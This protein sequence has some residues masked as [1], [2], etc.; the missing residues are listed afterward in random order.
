MSARS[1]KLLPEGRYLVT[2]SDGHGARVFRV[3]H[4]GLRGPR[5]LWQWGTPTRECLAGEW[6]PGQAAARVRVGGSVAADLRQL[7]ADPERAW[8]A[9]L[10]E[11]QRLCP[12]VVLCARC[13]RPLHDPASVQ[14]GEGPDCARHPVGVA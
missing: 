10:T 3:T 9:W 2:R 14:R 8:A 4:R 5:I 7:L 1:A 13:Q 12:T 6:M 11:Q